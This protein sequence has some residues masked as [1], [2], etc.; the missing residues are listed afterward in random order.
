MVS[1]CDVARWL[2]VLSFLE[3]ERSEQV[4]PVYTVG[5]SCETG[6]EV[7]WD[8]GKRGYRLPTEAEWEYATRA[9]TTSPWWCGTEPSCAE[10]TDWF[11]GDG[12]GHHPVGL[13]PANP[14]G[15]HDVH[16]NVVELVWDWWGV[17]PEP[18]WETDLPTLDQA[19]D[20]NYQPPPRVVQPGELDPVGP[21]RS[22]NLRVMRGG[23]T[24][25]GP[26]EGQVAE[27]GRA[28][29]EYG[30]SYRGFRLALDKPPAP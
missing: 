30:R 20:P 18:T 3:A 29:L 15:L 24:F 12:K 14:W 7:V 9:G 11:S 25:G 1:W 13:K 19:L 10:E 28:M 27:R 4:G 17:P 23:S 16:G 21:T 26:L 2:N 22:E 8:R 6:G 5:P